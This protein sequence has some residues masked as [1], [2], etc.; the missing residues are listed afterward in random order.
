MR[1]TGVTPAAYARGVRAGWPEALRS[2]A[3]TRQVV[4]SSSTTRIDRSS[5]TV[6][7]GGCSAVMAG[8]FFPTVTFAPPTVLRNPPIRGH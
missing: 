1:A 4:G 5:G 7:G 6:V 8:V 2:R 3:T